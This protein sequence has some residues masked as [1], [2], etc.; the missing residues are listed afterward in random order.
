MMGNTNVSTSANETGQRLIYYR[1]GQPCDHPGC[2]SHVSHP[3]ERCGRIAARGEATIPF[4]T[5]LIYLRD[6]AFERETRET[7]R[8]TA[9]LQLV[10]AVD[11]R[12]EAGYHFRAA[13]GRLLTRLDD[14]IRALLDDGLKVAEGEKVA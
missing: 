3:C 12:L 10:W 5:D 14:V 9:A 11:V 7:I 4:K 6:L 13:D 1:S 2:A 8:Y